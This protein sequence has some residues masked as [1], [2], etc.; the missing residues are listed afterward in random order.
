MAVLHLD[1]AGNVVDHSQPGA[2]SILPMAVN[3]TRQ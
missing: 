3:F 1:F 2:T